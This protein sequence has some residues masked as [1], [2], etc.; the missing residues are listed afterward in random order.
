M[1]N[2]IEQLAD[3]I[4]KARTPVRLTISSDGLTQISVLGI[5]NLGMI[6]NHPL[7]LNPGKY[8]VVGKKSGFQDVREEV[9]LTGD[10]PRTDLYV[11]PTR[12]L[13]TL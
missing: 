11:V 10:E 13:G 6:R 9:I 4:R 1:A 2:Q 3:T 5:S 12:S 8:V 7:D